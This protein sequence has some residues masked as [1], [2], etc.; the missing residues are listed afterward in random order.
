MMIWLLIGELAIGLRER[1]AVPSVL[2]LLRQHHV[3]D[4]FVAV[5]VSAL[6]ALFGA[7]VGPVISYFSDRYRSRWGRRIPFILATSPVCALALVG[8][9]YCSQLGRG[10][11]QLLGA[12]SPGEDVCIIGWFCLLW[13]VFQ[14]T[15]LMTGALYSGLV[16]DV[17]P[18]RIL[19]R[20]YAGVRMVS[21]GAGVIFNLWIFEW[22]ETHLR[23]VLLM[24]AALF[25]GGLVLMSLKVHEGEDARQP[26]SQPAPFQPWH[27]ARAMLRA[28]RD[29]CFGDR[30]FV[31]IFGMFMLAAVTYIPFN[32]F[33]QYYSTTL[34]LPKKELGTLLAIV[35][36][37][38]L[39][40]SFG[41][42]WCVDRYGALRVCSI[43]LTA[44]SLVSLAAYL[45]RPT[46]ATF[47]LVYVLH[48][49]ISGAWYTASAALPMA[50]FPQDRFLQFNAAKDLV[51]S[52]G[53]ILTS[54]LLGPLLDYSG[55]DYSLTLLIGAVAAGAASLCFAV[56][57]GKPAAPAAVIPAK[58]G[59]HAE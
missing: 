5:A 52:A 23:E 59:I 9:A 53:S 19:G 56:L 16:N 37:A 27:H 40:L 6:P 34:G 10:L 7:F 18:H 51:V 47:P 35:Y 8:L 28:Y 41:V 42:G 33:S 4:T 21:L 48:G 24:L 15:A 30:Y 49:V 58:A 26:L 39:L 20:F 55:H 50:L 36:C 38:S 1:S 13:T 57:R 43:V 32:T 46:L 44:Y 17:I 31:F 12:A 29:E 14:C 25:A 54:I 45:G 11:H 2:E 22:T 3:S